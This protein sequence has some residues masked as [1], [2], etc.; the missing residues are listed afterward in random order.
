MRVLHVS[1]VVLAVG[2]AALSSADFQNGSFE[3]PTLQN[4]AQLAVTG[5]QLPDW[6]ISGGNSV[7]ITNEFV[8]DAVT[9]NPTPDGNQFLYVNSD[10]AGG[11][12]LSQAVSLT[13]N[14]AE[15]LNFL[16]AD[17]GTNFVLPGGELTVSIYNPSNQLV[18]GPTLFTTPNY[19]GFIAQQLQFTTGAAGAYTFD[20]TSVTYHAGII[21]GVSLQPAPEPASLAAL[22]LSAAALARRRRMRQG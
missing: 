10:V 14:A 8:G 20:F 12:V 3:Q 18:V 9:W 17:F 16:Q 7:L 5:T 11:V 2:V 4:G 22:G 15:S 13:A 6:T 21:D 19:S 1:G